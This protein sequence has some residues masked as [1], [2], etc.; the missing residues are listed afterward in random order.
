[1]DTTDIPEGTVTVV[2]TDVEAR[3]RVFLRRALEERRR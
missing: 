2:F 1:M 3:L